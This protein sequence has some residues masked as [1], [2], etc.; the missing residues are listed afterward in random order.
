MGD[1]WLGGHSSSADTRI[2][3]AGI[4]SSVGTAVANAAAAVVAERVDG[5]SI[6]E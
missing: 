6:G 2:Y 4:R 3:W 5:R 1:T